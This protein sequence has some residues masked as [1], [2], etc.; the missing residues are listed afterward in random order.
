MRRYIVHLG[1]FVLALGLAGCQNPGKMLESDLNYDTLYKQLRKEDEQFVKIRSMEQ[2]VE[3][4]PKT[5]EDLIE[6]VLPVYNPLEDTTVSIS[7]QEETLHNVLYIVARNAGLNLVIEPGISLDNRVTISFEDASSALVVEKLLQA[8]DLAWE[9]EDNILY[10]Q[11]FAE[12]TFHL[13]FVNTN[14]EVSNNGGGDIFGS[15]LSGSGDLQGNFSLESTSGGDF[16]DNSLYGQILKS[17]DSILSEESAFG[18]QTV[19]GDEPENPGYFALDPLTGT[20]FV[21][22]T[23]GKIRA[24]AKVLNNLKSKLSKQVVIDARIMEVR[25]DDEFHFG[26]DFNWVA[27][28]MA[29]GDGTTAISLLQRSSTAYGAQTYADN[30]TAMTITGFAKGDDTFN[31]AVEAMQA[32]GGVKVVAN[33]HVRAKHG[34]PALFAAGTSQR[35]VSGIDRDVDDNGNVTFTVETS[36]VFNGVML[37]VIAYIS[38]DDR[39]DLQIFPI[40]SEVAQ[41]SLALVE[42]T[43]AGDKLTLPQVDVKNVS[44]TV[45]VSDGD[46][47]ILGGLIDKN[48]DKTDSGIPGVSNIP[49]LGWLFKTRTEN[50]EIR[51]MVVVMNVRVVK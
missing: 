51:E 39:V 30:N 2:Q 15:A 3:S 17:V 44:T 45:R 9:V 6:P 41:A 22:S 31:A 42:V 14:T 43:S 20:L 37:G 27:Q 23:P 38:D 40:K 24:V 7:V 29:W 8:Y 4:S 13:D 26:I 35:Y 10:V 47:I 48:H 46:T 18:S 49:I 32:F 12:E 19:T 28:R 36:N 50:D 25:L 16:S 21:R 33:P 34:Q 5:A 11:R 1:L